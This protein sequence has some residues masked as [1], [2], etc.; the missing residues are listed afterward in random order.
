MWHITYLYKAVA[1]EK[2]AQSVLLFQRVKEL[3]A[4]NETLREKLQEMYQESAVSQP[5]F[6]CNKNLKRVSR[7]CIGIKTY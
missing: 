2:T 4:Q 7:P 6:I 3:E 5:N 1:G